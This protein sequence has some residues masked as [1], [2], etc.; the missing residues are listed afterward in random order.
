MLRPPTL[1]ATLRVHQSH[2]HWAL[3]LLLQSAPCQTLNPYRL[4]SLPIHM[5]PLRLEGPSVTKILDYHGQLRSGQRTKR[6]WCYRH[7]I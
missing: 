1:R 6:D 7:L 3:I 5:R 2:Q 4:V